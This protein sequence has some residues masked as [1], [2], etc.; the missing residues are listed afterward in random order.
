[1]QTLGLSKKG[2]TI[3]T[4]PEIMPVSDPY[5]YKPKVFL[6]GTID[7]GNAEDWQKE[8]CEKLKGLNIIIFNPRRDPWPSDAGDKVIDEQIK[9]ELDRLKETDLIIINILPD[10]KSPISLMEMGLY[11]QSYKLIVFCDEHF[12]R[13]NNVKNVCEMY[14]IHLFN[15]NSNDF[16]ANKI[17]QSLVVMRSRM[18]YSNW[19]L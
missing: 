12:Y 13:Y 11:A 8:V 10:S 6:G 5:E 7:N 1:M 19:E 14:N 15:N 9:W 4:A 2:A 16:I 3:I 18:A 17:I